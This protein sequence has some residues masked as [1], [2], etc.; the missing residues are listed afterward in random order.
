[1]PIKNL[2]PFGHK[3]IKKPPASKNLDN[4]SLMKVH[5]PV[6]QLTKG[7]YVCEL[8]RP[9]VG[10]PFMFQGFEITTDEEILTLRDICHYVFVD[11]TKRQKST[12]PVTKTVVP[13]QKE[14][15]ANVIGFGQPPKKLGEFKNE[16]LRAEKTYENVEL[17]VTEFMNRVENGGGIDSI[18]A[19]NAVADCVN[20]VLHSPDA[21]LWLTQLRNKDEFTAL[22]SLNVCLLSIVLGRHINLSTADLNKLGLCGMMHD[23]GKML[24]PSAILH[25]KEMLTLEEIQIMKTHTTL[26]YELLKAND[27]M[28]QSA[29]TVALT[30]HERL[31]GKGYPRQLMQNGISPF[32]KIVAI[33]NAYDGI[34]S[35]KVNQKRKTHLQAIRLLTNMAGSFFEPSLVVKFIES[36][37]VYPPGCLVE[38]TNGA[39]AIV[40]EVHDEYKLRPKVILILNDLKEPADE[41]IIDLSEMVTDSQGNLYTI[42]NIINAEDKNIDTQKYNQAELLQRGFAPKKRK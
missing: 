1:M 30:H 2:W 28:S 3:T 27:N 13:P 9:W 42:K 25:K 18:V 14:K 33:A 26:G 31:D 4:I 34:T 5:T 8:D 16:I 29:I 35:H 15:L 20:S 32:A 37:G 22:H 21:M 19:K 40:I 38:M 41:Q 10:T 24:I 39:V 17:V 6:N 23:M 11:M 12:F 7:M 36:M